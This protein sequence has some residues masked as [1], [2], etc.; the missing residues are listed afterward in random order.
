VPAGYTG[1]LNPVD[2]NLCDLTPG[3]LTEDYL[4]KML[5]T[6][7]VASAVVSYWLLAVRH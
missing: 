3:F 2:L 5:L 4:V 1:K 7:G 6:L